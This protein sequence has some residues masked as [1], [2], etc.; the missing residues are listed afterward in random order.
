MVEV[1]RKSHTR[2]IMQYKKGGFKP[3]LHMERSFFFFF[4]WGEIK[5][6][7]ISIHS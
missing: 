7:Y 2:W 6:L 5:F 4:A 1:T 3:F